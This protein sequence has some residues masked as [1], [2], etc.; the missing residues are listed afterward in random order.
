MYALHTCRCCADEQH[1][2][3]RENEA[4]EQEDSAVRFLLAELRDR[5][6]QQ[7]RAPQKKR[8]EL[9]DVATM[10]QRHVFSLTAREDF[11]HKVQGLTT[12]D[13]GRIYELG[14]VVGRGSTSTVYLTK[15]RRT[16][17]AWATKVIDESVLQRRDW[18]RLSGQ[19]AAEIAALRACRHP[20]IVSL[21]NAIIDAHDGRLY[22]VFEYLSGGELFDYVVR[23]GTLSEAEA[24]AV[25]R[26]VASAVAYMH[27]QHVIH[28]D[29]KPENLLLEREPPP[30]ASPT[31]KIID[32]GLSKMLPLA[33]EGG[34]EATNN[35]DAFYHTASSFLGTR[36]YLAPEMLKRKRYSEAIDIWAFGVIAYVLLCGC[37]PFDD[38]LSK[39]NSPIA[40][41]KF[42]ALRYPS[43][44][45][46]LSP[47]AKDFLQGLLD[48]DPNRRLTAVDA[49]KHT[50]LYPDT[51]IPHNI[52]RS[53][54]LIKDRR[55]Q[56]NKIKKGTPVTANQLKEGLFRH[57]C[58]LRYHQMAQSN[59]PL[60]GGSAQTDTSLASCDSISRWRDQDVNVTFNRTPV[61]KHS[62]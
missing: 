16:G 1:R 35:P 62:F 21:D 5:K 45:S 54:A 12:G 60:V 59:E 44:A 43:W 31:V 26:D 39:I 14:P 8:M 38:D 24:A 49:A 2:R 30:S 61:R 34:V 22:L 6:E 50:W 52:L 29:L 42:G 56:Q 46:T 55:H 27:S 51:Q 41:R 18:N 25:L 11:S 28:R 10:D 33:R 20:H 40:G 37:L 36:G 15:C 48:V 23:K 13:F 17:T 19:F 47:K 32:F 4:D 3:H 53:P 9:E 58:P 7:K 57:R